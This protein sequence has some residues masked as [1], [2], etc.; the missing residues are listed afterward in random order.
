MG[1]RR[2]KG[3][4]I[5]RQRVDG[6]A[7]V[8][9]AAL[10]VFAVVMVLGITGCGKGEQDQS[11]GVVGVEKIGESLE[12]ESNTE[13]GIAHET[14]VDAYID[15][16]VL[17]A[18]NPD[19]FAWLYVPGTGIDA[20]VLQSAEADDYYEFHNAYGEADEGGALFTELAN[21]K[22]MCDFNTVIH[23]KTSKDGTKGLFVDLYKFAD[24]DFFEKHENIY[25][26]LD[27]NLLTYT[28]FAAFER[29]NSSLIRSY[30]FTYGSGCEQF[31]KDLYDSRE[32][33]KNLREGWEGVS[34]YHFLLTL[35][36][37]QGGD[38]VRQFVVVAAL[39]GDAAGT[40][41]RAVEW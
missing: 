22:D 33:G 18:E 28:V 16:T 5:R 8:T 40:V 27:G 25:L 41:D 36:T 35:S 6:K 29:E 4:T 7:V 12:A 11:G 32:M 38:A 19:I 9:V 30:D 24:P 20:P 13:T 31:L 14:A 21:L 10:P 23:G 39:V 1:K 26:Y 2:K 17:K 34:P 3:K 37:Q 15:F